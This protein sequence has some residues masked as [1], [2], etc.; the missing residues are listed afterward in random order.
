MKKEKILRENQKFTEIINKNN[1]LKNKYYSIYYEKS[2]TNKYGITIPKKIAKANVRNRI[3]RRVKNIIVKN[4]KF[5][6][7][8]YNYVIIVKKAILELNYSNMEE[9]LIKLMKKE[10]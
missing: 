5:I 9:E 2:E 7:K 8:N 4:E 10:R 3:K 6:Q 1:S